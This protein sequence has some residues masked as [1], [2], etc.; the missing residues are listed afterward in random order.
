[1]HNLAQRTCWRRDVDSGPAPLD[2]CPLTRTLRHQLVPWPCGRYPPRDRIYDLYVAR[3]VVVE[4]LATQDLPSMSYTLGYVPGPRVVQVSLF[5]GVCRQ[6]LAFFRN[7]V[8]RG[9]R[10]EKIGHTQG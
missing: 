3:I 8:S 10:Y 5:W 7:R 6:S 9:G 2:E 1:M 4:H